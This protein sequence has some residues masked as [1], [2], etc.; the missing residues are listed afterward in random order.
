MENK[1]T[2]LKKQTVVIIVV[3]A[4]AAVTAIACLVFPYIFKEEL[5]TVYSKSKYGDEVEALIFD[6][7]SGTYLNGSLEA[8]L[9]GEVKNTLFVK[10]GK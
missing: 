1:K 2:I 5:N 9:S 10:P 8:M 6:K 3:A 7:N 4:L